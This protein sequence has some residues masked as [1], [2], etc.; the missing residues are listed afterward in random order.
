MKSPRPSSTA[1][2]TFARYGATLEVWRNRCGDD[3]ALVEPLLCP[4]DG[5][6]SSWPG[7]LPSRPNRRVVHL[8]G[9]RYRAI[10]DEG[11]SEPADLSRD[12][13]VLYRVDERK[14]RSALCKALELTASRD[15]LRPLPGLL[16]IGQWRYS[17]S[18][19]CPVWLACAATDQALAEHFRQVTA[20]PSGPSIVLLL[21]RSAWG[22]ESERYAPRDR[23][24]VATIDDAVSW[25]ENE[26]SEAADWDELLGGF[27]EAAGIRV[28]GG[29]RAK[30]KKVKV[31]KAGGTAAKLKH[32]I[33]AWYRGAKEHLIEHGDLLPAPSRKEL[34]KACGVSESTVSRWL[35]TKYAEE[36]RE[37]HHLW[38]GV[39]DP[40]RVRA[41]RG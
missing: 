23:L 17:P 16:R 14:L 10:C 35:K 9:S 25:S 24:L 18:T 5:I 30:K 6:A 32:E 22:T 1:I 37:L 21:T 40:A 29:F 39:I 11:L 2:E 41:F 36:D 15:D 26:W 33:K 27:I 12:Q 28:S 20:V 13:L 34:A 3:F 38:A 7:R 4:T 31:A 8:D 19:G